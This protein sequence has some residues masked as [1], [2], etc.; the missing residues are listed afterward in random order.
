MALLTTAEAARVLGVAAA[1]LNDW[2]VRN[3]GP[4]Y[5]KIG[6]LVRYSDHELERFIRESTVQTSNRKRAQRE[7]REMGVP[8]SPERP[9]LLAGHRFRGRA[10][11]RF[12]GASAESCTY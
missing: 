8:I 9:T 12:A 1:T 2:R 5:T 6:R 3:E 4:A 7:A 10:R 11:K